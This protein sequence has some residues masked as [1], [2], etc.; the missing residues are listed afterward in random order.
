MLVGRAIEL[1]VAA[2][3]YL[4]QCRVR[5]FRLSAA[6][7]H[8][9]ADPPVLHAGVRVAR[10][11]VQPPC[12]ADL[13]RGE[14]H[15][16]VGFAQVR[17]KTHHVAALVILLGLRT[18]GVEDAIL[19]RLR[20]LLPLLAWAVGWTPEHIPGKT[21]DVSAG[22]LDSSQ[23]KRALRI[24]NEST[25]VMSARLN[26]L[27]SCFYLPYVKGHHATFFTGAV[28]AISGSQPRSKRFWSVARVIP[29][30]RAH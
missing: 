29:A 26:R 1:R 11:R 30:S 4:V 5:D 10:P 6:R 13:D 19:E 22:R 2:D 21:D 15:V 8:V 9:I 14:P 3:A 28:T 25:P 18:N 20:G 17:V 12:L 16:A 24:K 27:R 23:I 7:R